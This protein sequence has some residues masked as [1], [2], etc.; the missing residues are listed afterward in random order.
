MSH[1]DNHYYDDDTYRNDS[2]KLPM[3]CEIKR[4]EKERNPT[5]QRKETDF[6]YYQ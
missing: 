5:E 1:D 2:R 3:N 6:Y 4:R